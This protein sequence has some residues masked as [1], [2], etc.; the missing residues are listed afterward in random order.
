MTV[1]E[2]GF[3][4]DVVDISPFT[5]DL[6]DEGR[7]A[8]TNVVA[9]S[10]ML[11]AGECDEASAMLVAADMV[12]ECY[13]EKGGI[14]HDGVSESC[15]AI[16]PSYYQ[17]RDSDRQL[18]ELLEPMDFCLGNAAKY[19]YRSMKSRTGQTK[20]NSEKCMEDVKKARWYVGRMMQHFDTA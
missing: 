12:L 17:A 13:L 3:F 11:S 19:I 2:Y 6:C 18:I 8:L 9:A 1:Y 15:D 14:E 7:Q 10:R 4:G 5:E 16:S 20:G